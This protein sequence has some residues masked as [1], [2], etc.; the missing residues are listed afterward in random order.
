MITVTVSRAC[1]KGQAPLRGQ[2]PIWGQAPRAAGWILEH[3]G[4]TVSQRSGLSQVLF[5][6][7][8]TMKKIALLSTVAAWVAA[9]ALYGADAPKPAWAEIVFDHPEKFTDIKDQVNPTDSGQQAILDRIRE[10]LVSEVKPYIPDGCKLT[11]TFTDIDLAGDFE[12][13]HGGQWDHI[14]IVKPIYPPAFK[15]AWTVTNLTGKV[16]KQGKEDIRDLSF[17]MRLTVNMDDPLRFEKD[18]LKDWV[19]GNLGDVKH[20]V[21]AN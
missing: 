6:K 2:A 16:I 7:E 1:R 14:R 12:P 17:D 9:G 21:A 10:Y 20:L 3:N 15:F 5:P 19:G 18:I 4:D 8:R 13:W 11:I